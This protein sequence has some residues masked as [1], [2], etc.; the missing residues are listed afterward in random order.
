MGYLKI[1]YVEIKCLGFLELFDIY[2]CIY[3]F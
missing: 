1:D 3:F 2:S